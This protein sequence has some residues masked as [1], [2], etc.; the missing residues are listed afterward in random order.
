MSSVFTNQVSASKWAAFV[1]A[2]SAQDVL[3]IDVV[4]LHRAAIPWLGRQ[5]DKV[6]Q[7]GGGEAIPV[8]G[9]IAATLGVPLMHERHL[10]QQDGGLE[11][12]ETEIA[13]HHAVVVPLLHAVIAHEAELV[14]EICVL[15]DTDASVSGGTE[16]L[17]RE[18]AEVGRIANGTC[19]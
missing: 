3:V 5:C 11:G 18:K 17:R 4:I 19:S 2:M 6:E 13:S 16:V 8:V 7:P 15:A 10:G 1:A 9:R 12:V 14:G